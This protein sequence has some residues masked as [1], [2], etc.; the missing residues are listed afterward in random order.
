M[1]THHNLY[2]G[3]TTAENVK[4][5]IGSATEELENPPEDMLVRGRDLL[6]EAKQVPLHLEKL[7]ST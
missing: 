5:Q 1:R 4:I 6:W 3:E 7:Q 2:V